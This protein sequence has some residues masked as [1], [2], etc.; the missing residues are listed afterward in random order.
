MRSL[1]LTM[2]V[3]FVAPI[4]GR[5]SGRVPPRYQMTIGMSMMTVALLIL[6]RL[7]VNSSYNMIWPAL[8]AGG[9]RHRND[10]AAVSASG[11]GAVDHAKAGVASGVINASRQVGGALGVAVLGAVVSTRVGNVWKG[12]ESLVP[13]VTGGQGT[14]IDEVVL[15]STGSPV[16]ARLAENQALT[17][18]RAR[19]AGRDAGGCGAVVLGGVDRV[20]RSAP[21]AGG[22]AAGRI[23]AAAGRVRK[24][25]GRV[26]RLPARTARDLPFRC[27]TPHQ[28]DVAGGARL[29]F[30]TGVMALWVGEGTAW[31]VTWRTARR[32]LVV[33]LIRWKVPVVRRGL[34]RARPDQPAA[35]MTAVIAIAMIVTGI[36]HSMG[37]ADIGPVTVLGVHLALAISLVPLVLRHVTTARSVPTGATS[38]GPGSCGWPVSRFW[39]WR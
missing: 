19:R 25:G 14:K 21:R 31:A 13:L 37:L 4:A 27:G 30:T 7:E 20:L 26:L 35:V 32:V 16:A 28:P 6:S 34:R 15:Q 3:I 8:R 38:R 2:M 12:P 36:A 23:A 22:C 17:S 11:M 24:P 5:R 9:R 10:D 29:A 33:L 39:P 18:S 1:P